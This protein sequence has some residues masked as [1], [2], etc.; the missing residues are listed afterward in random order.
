MDDALLVRG[1][2]RRAICDGEVERLAHAGSAPRRRAA[3]R[4][5]APSSSSITRKGAPSSMPK[6]WTARMCGWSSAAVARASRSKRAQAIG[7]SRQFCGE[8]FDR[9]VPPELRVVRAVDLAHPR[10]PQASRRS[11]TG[12]GGGPR[13][14][15]SRHYVESSLVGMGN[16]RPDRACLRNLPCSGRRRSGFPARGWEPCHL[17]RDYDSSP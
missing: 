16:L 3:S 15:T 5:S 2:E 4:A 6:S 12:R 17:L 14:M 10:P 8:H 9:D 1:R 13:S 11:C 7:V